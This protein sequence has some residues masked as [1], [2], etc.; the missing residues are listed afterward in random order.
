MSKP[1]TM[2]AEPTRTMI[3]ETNP[4][5]AAL[6]E[7]RWQKTVDGMQVAADSSGREHP[8]GTTQRCRQAQKQAFRWQWRGETVHRREAGTA[9]APC[10]RLI[11]P[12][13]R[14]LPQ[15]AACRCHPPARRPPPLRLRQPSAAAE[16]DPRKGRESRNSVV[17]T[18][19]RR[20]KR[21]HEAAGAV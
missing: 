9:A 2:A 17:H 10:P 3:E 12:P 4:E 20:H 1:A 7:L 15:P 8:A 21:N 11:P 5:E 6:L 16:N 18:R 14:P 13:R 19:N